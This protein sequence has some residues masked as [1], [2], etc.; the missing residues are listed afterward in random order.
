MPTRHRTGWP[1]IIRVNV[2]MVL[3]IY[4]RKIG[5]GPYAKDRRNGIFQGNTL[6]RPRLILPFTGIITSVA[7]IMYIRNIYPAMKSNGNLLCII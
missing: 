7:V 3:I 4:S 6:Q 2:S 1:A 5:T